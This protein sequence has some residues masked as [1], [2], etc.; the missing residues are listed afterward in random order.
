MG[1][2]PRVC[3]E[4]NSYYDLGQTKPGSPPRMRGK[5]GVYVLGCSGHGIT[6]A[7]A[8]K[9][10][11]GV[12]HL[13]EPGDHPRVCGEKG[14]FQ[15]QLQHGG[16]SPPRMRGK[17]FRLC[18]LRSPHRITPAYA[19]KS[20]RLHPDG[21]WCWDHPRVCGEKCTACGVSPITVGITP[22]YAGKR[23]IPPQD[24]PPL[25]DHPRVCGEKTKKIP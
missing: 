11:C 14:G 25:G 6:P 10:H 23:D 22:A 4:K 13:G 18:L 16:G 24:S 3:G 5:D 15:R 20:H 1:D 8:G 17:V 12:V 21:R 19:G 2:H 7:Y 9:R